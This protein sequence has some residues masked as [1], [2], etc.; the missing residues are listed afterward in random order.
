MRPVTTQRS[1][2]EPVRPFVRFFARQTD[3]ALFTVAALGG[4]LLLGYPLA[5]ADPRLL[6]VVF[7][8]AWALV[9][10]A[11]LCVVGTTPG[12]W[13]L[14]TS[15]RK[16]D[17]SRLSFADALRRS[18]GVWFW[19]LGLGI[20]FVSL[21]AAIY[22]FGR[23]KRVG[24]AAWD[25]NLPSV[26]RHGQVGIRQA[27]EVVALVTACTYLAVLLAQAQHWYVAPGG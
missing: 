13:L 22:A 1:P 25:E 6:G 8:P 21:V 16:V 17:G 14:R 10:T 3:L 4:D 18:L 27:I 24:C 9:E 15:V 7:L 23:L 5:R 19:G 11:L 20:P 2:Q 26:V 12:K